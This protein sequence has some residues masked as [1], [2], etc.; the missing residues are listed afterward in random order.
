MT[1]YE[2]IAALEA[3]VARLKSENVALKV[4][5]EML[6]SSQRPVVLPSIKRANAR[7]WR[8]R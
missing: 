4:A 3:E 6:R 8:S 2:R 7:A 1:D 5:N